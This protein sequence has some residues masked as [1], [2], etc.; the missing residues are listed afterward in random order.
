MPLN[1][2]VILIVRRATGGKGRDHL[3]GKY[4]G[5]I[6]FI[7][8]FPGAP[9]GIATTVP[10]DVAPNKNKEVKGKK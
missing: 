8:W 5:S 3:K 2:S 10:P 1:V 6:P 4:L 7:I 9:L